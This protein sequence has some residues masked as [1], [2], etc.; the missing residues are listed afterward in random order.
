MEANMRENIPHI[1]RKN[2]TK[3]KVLAS[4]RYQ[5][6]ITERTDKEKLGYPL[7]SGNRIRSLLNANL[8]IKFCVYHP[9]LYVNDKLDI[10]K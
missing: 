10:I 5:G 3:K 2:T 6:I 1:C 4:L 9:P 7:T 8:T